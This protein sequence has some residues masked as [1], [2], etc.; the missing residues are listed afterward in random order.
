MDYLIAYQ[1]AAK[2]Q[3]AGVKVAIKTEEIENVRNLP[4]NAGFAATYGMGTE[5]ALRAVT[6]EPAEIFGVSDRI[7]SIE[8]GKIANLFIAN[9]DP[10][11][12]MTD[13]EQV[14]ING[15]KIPMTNRHRQLYE[16]FLNR[17]S[18]VETE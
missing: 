2:L 6:I 9:G 1:N 16:Q 10:F 17:D 12:P 8:E 4:F 5:Q 7:G 3:E 13:I 14:F 11:E 15:F 18:T